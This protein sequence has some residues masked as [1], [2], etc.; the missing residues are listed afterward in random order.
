[1]LNVKD[2]YRIVT[3]CTGSQPES[4]NSVPKLQSQKNLRFPETNFDFLDLVL[5]NPAFLPLDQKNPNT[6]MPRRHVKPQNL[7]K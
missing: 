5:K 6:P 3:L 1:M 7:E 4:Q 2:T